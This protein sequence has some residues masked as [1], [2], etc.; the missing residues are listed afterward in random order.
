MSLSPEEF[1]ALVEAYGTD[2]QRWPVVD[3]VAVERLRRHPQCSQA[4]QDAQRLDNLLDTH[5]VPAFEGLEARL[6]QQTLPVRQPGLFERLVSWLIPP[7]SNQSLM[8]WW[9]PLAL[10]S[11]PLMLGLF[12][13]GQYYPAIDYG[14]ALSL[15]EE[16]YFISF[17]DYAEVM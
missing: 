8:P 16:L 6:L 3:E 1:V 15:E 12:I 7:T 11:V 5:A 17:S 2:L 10:A 9:R 4:W 13:G 14:Q